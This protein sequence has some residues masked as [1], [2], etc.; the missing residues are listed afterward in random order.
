MELARH[1]LSPVSI[2][3]VNARQTQIVRNSDKKFTSAVKL[4]A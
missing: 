3:H 1:T 4:T 2:L